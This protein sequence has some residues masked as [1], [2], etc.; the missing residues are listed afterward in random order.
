MG[1]HRTMGMIFSTHLNEISGKMICRSWLA[2]NVDFFSKKV[3]IISLHLSQENS[4]YNTTFIRS[5]CI[6]RSGRYDSI[7][8]HATLINQPLYA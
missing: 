3:T 4:E 7:S 5:I 2:L 8:C 1:N 6:I